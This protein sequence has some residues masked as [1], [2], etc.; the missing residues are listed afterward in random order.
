MVNNFGSLSAKF[1]ILKEGG[2]RGGEREEG[3]GGGAVFTV[4]H[5]FNQNSGLFV[6]IIFQQNYQNPAL[7]SKIGTRVKDDL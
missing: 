2:R 5:Y 4:I 3:G 1:I 7:I 6:Q